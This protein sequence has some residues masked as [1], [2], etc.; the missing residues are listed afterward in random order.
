MSRPI[1]GPARVVAARRAA[2]LLAATGIFLLSHQP[3]RPSV[4]LFKYQD[5]VFHLVE[6]F[7]FGLVVIWNR[8]LFPL[9]GRPAAMV[10]LGIAYAML[11]EIH[12]AFV[13]GRDCS[14][15]DFAAQAAGVLL[16]VLVFR[17]L[18]YRGSGRRDGPGGSPSERSLAGS[19]GRR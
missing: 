8:D 10:V 12:Q 6:F 11:D 7:L 4:P 15:A 5:K 9:R 18:V 13:P 17:R 1:P 2:L 3:S 14:V 19:P 16:C